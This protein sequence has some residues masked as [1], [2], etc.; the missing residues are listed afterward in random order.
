VSS[1]FEL[2]RPLPGATFGGRLIPVG[3]GG[4]RALI[5]AAE[6]EPDA[7]PRALADCQGLMLIQAMDA[8]ADEPELLLRLSRRFGPEV[9]NYRE[10]LTRCRRSSW[11]RT[12]R[13][14]VVLRP[15]CR[16]RP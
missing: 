2:A 9:E 4:A 13:R 11:S 6:R 1:S 8:M 16:P 7:L 14:P 15:P 10:N 12:R 3:T 5:E